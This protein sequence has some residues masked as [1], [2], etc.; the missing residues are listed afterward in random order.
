MHHPIDGLTGHD[1][2]VEGRTSADY[3]CEEKGYASAETFTVLD[4]FY[5]TTLYSFDNMSDVIV[6]SME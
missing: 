5:N 2:C 6:Y 3:S 1:R 4:P